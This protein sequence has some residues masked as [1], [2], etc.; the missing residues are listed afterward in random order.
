VVEISDFHQRVLRR[1]KSPEE[2]HLYR[3]GL[4][5]DLT[6]PIVIESSEDFKSAP[7][8]KDRLTPYQHQVNNLITFCRRLPVTL[9]ADDVGLGKTISAGLVISELASRSRVSKILIV[10]PKILG[11]QWC[12]ELATKFD[13]PSQFVTGRELVT[14]DFEDFGAVI[15]S[16]AISPT[17]NAL[18]IC[19]QSKAL[20]GLRT[21]Y[22]GCVF[23][24]RE[25][26]IIGSVASGKRSKGTWISD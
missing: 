25:R 2:M 23:S 20:L 3:T 18:A 15:L 5:W 12:A 11:P 10:C 6:D 7:Q 4:E 21:S 16:G 26:E 17:G 13:I 19:T 9:L 24:P 8:W 14:T 1:A 22:L